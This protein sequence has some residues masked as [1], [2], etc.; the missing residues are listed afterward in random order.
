MPL[1]PLNRYLAKWA[2]VTGSSSGIGKE[3][4]RKLLFQE[5]DVILV[6]REEKLFDE[7]V[8]ELRALFPK[9]QA[10]RVPAERA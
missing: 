9:R 3:L 6:A 8:A 2:L 4:A 1:R 5:M 7:T 10:R